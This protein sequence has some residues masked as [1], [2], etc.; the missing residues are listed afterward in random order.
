[1]TELFKKIV[2][3]NSNKHPSLLTDAIKIITESTLPNNT[4]EQ[5]NTDY[6]N[7]VF[8]L[9]FADTQASFLCK[10][11]KTEDRIHAAVCIIIVLKNHK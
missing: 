10:S 9:G 3:L 8:R 6:Y 1:M 11:S 5:C 7:R 4:V 2:A